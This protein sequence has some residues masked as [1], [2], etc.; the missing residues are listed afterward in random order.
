MLVVSKAILT[1]EADGTSGYEIINVC[2]GQSKQRE[3]CLKY[4]LTQ[5]QS[6]FRVY[7]F[8]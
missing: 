4:N 5:D 8:V 2:Q 7:W 1:R 6:N 3:S